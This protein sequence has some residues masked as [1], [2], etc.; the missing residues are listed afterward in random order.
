MMLLLL[1]FLFFPTLAQ[2]QELLLAQTTPP[3]L[4]GAIT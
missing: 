4:A 2:A 3:R 1:A